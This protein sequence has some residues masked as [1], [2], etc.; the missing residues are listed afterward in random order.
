MTEILAHEINARIGQARLTSPFVSLPFRIVI[1]VVLL[2]VS[3]LIT[4]EK[5]LFLVLTV[6]PLLSS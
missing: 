5:T 6:S 2:Q 1:P 4:S 3:C